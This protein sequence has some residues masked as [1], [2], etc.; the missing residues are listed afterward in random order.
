MSKGLFVSGTKGRKHEST[1]GRRGGG[2][3]S[4]YYTVATGPEL[5]RDSRELHRIYTDF[6][7]NA[8]KSLTGLTGPDEQ[9]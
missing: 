5:H 6:M 4:V 9:K 8:V 3:A 7:D 2:L 1:K